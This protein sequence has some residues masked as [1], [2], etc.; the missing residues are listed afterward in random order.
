MSDKMFAPR[1]MCSPA[2]HVDCGRTRSRE[3]RAGWRDW[4]QFYSKVEGFLDLVFFFFFRQGLMCP[5]LASNSLWGQEWSRMSCIFDSLTIL[6]DGIYVWTTMLSIHG[7]WCSVHAR[8]LFYQMS[9]IPGFQNLKVFVAWFGHK[10]HHVRIQTW[11]AG[12]F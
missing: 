4:Y 1:Q 9:C 7:T 2:V 6:S 10:R 5:T 3:L 12:N 8:Q 11:T